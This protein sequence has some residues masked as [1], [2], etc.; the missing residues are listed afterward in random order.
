MNK[1]R[2]VLLA[3]GASMFAAP[4]PSFAQQPA[5]IPRIG[6]L[7]PT[8]AA[9]IASGLEGFRAGLR[10]LGYVEGKTIFVDWRWRN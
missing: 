1:R 2:K 8:T 4:L 6:F 10:D 3:F 5:K 7:G 9:G